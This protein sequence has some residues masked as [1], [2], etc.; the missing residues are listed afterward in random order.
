MLT[1]NHFYHELQNVFSGKS[2]IKFGTI[3]Q[4]IA[5]CLSDGQQIVAINEDEKHFKEQETNRLESFAAKQN[6]WTDR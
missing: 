5:R 3:I 6:R 1:K 2:Q 4:S